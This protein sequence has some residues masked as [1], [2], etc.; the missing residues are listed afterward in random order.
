VTRD[1]EA[2]VTAHGPRWRELAFEHAAHR[3]VRFVPSR[4][5]AAEAWLGS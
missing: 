4:A 5:A 2:P 1:G 3:V